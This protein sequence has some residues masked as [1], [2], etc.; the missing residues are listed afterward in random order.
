[1]FTPVSTALPRMPLMNVCLCVCVCLRTR[2]CTYRAC[3][4]T[5]TSGEDV[6][7]CVCVC[8]CVRVCR[9]LLRRMY[10]VVSL[11]RHETL[12][13]HHLASGLATSGFTWLHPTHT[14]PNTTKPSR[15]ST[16]T[17]PD[18]A[19]QATTGKATTAHAARSQKN[20]QNSAQ[21][22]A[23]QGR[24]K[25][26]KSGVAVSHGVSGRAEHGV[27]GISVKGVSESVQ[28]GGVSVCTNGHARVVGRKPAQ[29]ATPCVHQQRVLDML[30][31]VQWLFA[32][33]V[34]PLLRAHFY[35]TETEPYKNQ[36]FYYRCVVLSTRLSMQCVI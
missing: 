7:V 14:H 20:M 19:S 36:V 1:M 4:R 16:S 35:I 9:L 21:A 12:H 30:T 27:S 11:R 32:H 31:W 33:L 29:R 22:L 6:C 24:S 10:Q 13:T 34:L 25:Q 26:H 28:H 18:R 8:V 5:R 3:L 17:A 2:T 15:T 23:L